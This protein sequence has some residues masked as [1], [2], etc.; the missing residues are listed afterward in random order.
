MV[1]RR[2]QRTDQIANGSVAGQEEQALDIEVDRQPRPSSSSASAYCFVHPLG[3]LSDRC[4]VSTALDVLAHGL[5][6]HL[7]HRPRFRFGLCHPRL[8]GRQS[9]LTWR[10]T[11]RDE[12]VTC[13]YALP[14]AR[15]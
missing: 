15:L 5:A 1:E 9:M 3:R 11:E 2:L 7:L 13:S 12:P 14:P 8:S 4:L 10:I 6:G